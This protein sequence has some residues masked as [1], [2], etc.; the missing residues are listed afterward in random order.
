MGQSAITRPSTVQELV[1]AELRR[2]LVA[3]ELPA[4]SRIGQEDLAER[5]GVSRHPIREALKVLEGEGQLS[6]VPRRGY[7]VTALSPSDL[8]EIYRM[9]QLLENEAVA[10]GTRRLTNDHL[11][12]L[13]QAHQA[14][15]EAIARQDLAALTAANRTFHFTLLKPAGMPRLARMVSQLWDAS[16]PYRARHFSD[17]ENQLLSHRE[18]GRILDAARQRD[19]ELLIQLLD[20]HRSHAVPTLRRT[21]GETGP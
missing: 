5:L 2:A 20:E 4:D 11:A 13:A 9:R 1:L 19:P 17:P 10:V 18:H 8:A 12:E 21:L 6:Y 3:G 15:A 16:N 7:F 14:M